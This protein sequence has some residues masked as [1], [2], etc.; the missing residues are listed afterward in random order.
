[1]TEEAVIHTINEC[2]A[3]GT[4]SR[5]EVGGKPHS[6]TCVYP[7]NLILLE[8]NF[9][10]VCRST[11]T[12]INPMHT[13]IMHSRA[14]TPTST[15]TATSPPHTTNMAAHQYNTIYKNITPPHHEV[16]GH[17][18]KHKSIPPR[19][20]MTNIS[21]ITT[22]H[23]IRGR[24]QTSVHIIVRQPA[25]HYIRHGTQIIITLHVL[26]HLSR[27]LTCELVSNYQMLLS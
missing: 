19:C 25:Y 8:L 5:D 16:R 1:M 13:I 3:L 12:T 11:I 26:T 20:R 4:I 2:I 27:S 6:F 18:N 21:C 17:G 15:T 23:H 14:Q 22:S 9:P 10:F 24:Q 7:T